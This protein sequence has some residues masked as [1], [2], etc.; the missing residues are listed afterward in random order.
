MRVRLS[1]TPPLLQSRQH[2]AVQP[3]KDAHP[4]VVSLLEWLVARA[5][6][7]GEPV[8]PVQPIVKRLVLAAIDDVA[9]KL[10]EPSS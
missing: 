6:Q 3:M 4:N 5:R 1:V 10:V 8:Q 9:A 2:Y 7:R